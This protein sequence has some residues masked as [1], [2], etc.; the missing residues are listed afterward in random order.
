L[1]DPASALESIPLTIMSIRVLHILDHSLPVQ[2]GYTF[3]TAALLREQH[4]L[5]IETVLLT[6]PKHQTSGARAMELLEEQFGDLIFHRTPMP[7][8]AAGLPGLGEWRQMRATRRRLDEL[9]ASTRPDILHAHSPALNALPAL[10]AGRAAGLPVVYEIR[11]FWEDAAVD[12]GTT[13]EGSL[14]YRATRGMETWA[15]RRVDHVFTICQ[16]L[17]GDLLARGVPPGRISVVPNAATPDP[18]SEGRQPDVELASALGIQGCEV[19]GFVGSFYAYEGLDLLIE[20]MPALLRERPA[21][22][23]LLVGGG[24]CDAA[25]RVRAEAL[26]LEGKVIFAGRVP[27]SQVERYYDLIDLL[28]YPRHPMRLTELVTPLKPLEC[29]SQGRVLLASDVG[30]HRELVV[31]GQTGFLFKA[32]DGPALVQRVLQV[33]GLREQWPRIRAQGRTFVETERNWARSASVH[34]EAYSRLL[35]GRG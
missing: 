20:V 3:R 31:D 26:G 24:P 4:K 17:K 9:I 18:E 8:G 2:T 16:G 21:L 23:L 30:G 32:G 6:T 13:T 29:M 15:A 28:V 1:P 27:H 7:A 5:G 19:L 14:R 25:L 22:R 12:H 33:L 35:A 34:A 11:G 10:W